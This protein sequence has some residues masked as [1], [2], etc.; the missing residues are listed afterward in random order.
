MRFLYLF[1]AYKCQHYSN[2][3]L[4]QRKAKGAERPALLE[5]GFAHSSRQ[6]DAKQIQLRYSHI[7]PFKKRLNCQ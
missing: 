1:V 4:L 6:A 2:T 5:E 7:F 3:C